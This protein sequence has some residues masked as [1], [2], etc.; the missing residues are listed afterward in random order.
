MPNLKH[1]VITALALL[2]AGHC[3]VVLRSRRMLLPHLSNNRAGIPSRTLTHALK[4]VRTAEGSDV[5]GFHFLK[6]ERKNTE[7]DTEGWQ[8]FHW[9]HP[10]S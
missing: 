6:K 1:R 3:V 8:R 7:H 2:P 10:Q 9:L 5:C 4:G